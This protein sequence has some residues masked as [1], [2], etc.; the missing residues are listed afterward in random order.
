M[1]QQ[2]SYYSNVVAINFI[3]HYVS[4]RLEENNFDS[5]NVR[6]RLFN[7]NEKGTAWNEQFNANKN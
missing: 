3:M 2:C 4:S 7:K 5:N 1:L 6:L